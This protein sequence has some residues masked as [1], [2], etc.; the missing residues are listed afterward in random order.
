MRS[1]TFQISWHKLFVFAT[2][3]ALSTFAGAQ[4]YQQTNLVSDV[5]QINGVPTNHTQPLDPQLVNPWGLTASAT[6]PF[7]V[8]DNGAGVSTLYQGTGAKVSLVVT[9]PAAAGEA[10]GTP[11]GT[12]F[13]SSASATNFS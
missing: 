8:F 1:E 6:S 5:D 4:R 9:I 11:T 12:V 2:I 13:N 7:W 3:L 10:M